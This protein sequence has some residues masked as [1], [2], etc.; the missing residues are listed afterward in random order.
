MEKVEYEKNLT[1]L[2]QELQER[3]K[4]NKQKL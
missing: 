1:L 3:K 2:K 4:R